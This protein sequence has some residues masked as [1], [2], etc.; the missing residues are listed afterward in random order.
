MAS[1]ALTWALCE[2]VEAAILGLDAVLVAVASRV[3]SVHP[4]VCGET[5]QVPAVAAFPWATSRHQKVLGQREDSQQN[6]GKLHRGSHPR[7]RHAEACGLTWGWV[8]DLKRVYLLG[9]TFCYSWPG[10]VWIL[11]QSKPAKTTLCHRGPCDLKFLCPSPV[12]GPLLPSPSE[13]GLQSNLKNRTLHS[14]PDQTNMTSILFPVSR[15]LCVCSHLSTSLQST[16]QGRRQGV[17]EGWAAIVLLP[18]FSLSLLPFSPVFNLFTPS[19]YSTSSALFC[20]PCPAALCHPTAW[21]ESEECDHLAGLQAIV[22]GG[23]LS[24]PLSVLR[25]MFGFFFFFYSCNL[26]IRKDSHHSQRSECSLCCG[27]RS[28]THLAPAEEHL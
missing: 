3:H 2:V 27:S 13:T 6:A 1:P 5:V 25:A 9:P 7:G 12:S 10:E 14:C 26:Y 21:N 23:P 19:L 28:L 24:S 11:V 18:T 22:P 17:R 16:V 20:Q 15:F 8:L 4:P